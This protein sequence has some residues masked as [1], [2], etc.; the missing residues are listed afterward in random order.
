MED[1]CFRSGAGA[2]GASLSV[3]CEGG[4]VAVGMGT[5]AVVA[6]LRATLFWT[7]NAKSGCKGIKVCLCLIG[8]GTVTDKEVEAKGT[9]V[10]LLCGFGAIENAFVFGACCRGKKKS[11]W[12]FLVST[13]HFDDGEN[14]VFSP[15]CKPGCEDSRSGGVG[16]TGGF[17]GGG[18]GVLASVL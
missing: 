11:G 12:D 15:L 3:C 14:D 18:R 17:G 9:N 2:T 16:T 4:R 13:V 6:A 7:L 8:R 1:S 5:M 10:C